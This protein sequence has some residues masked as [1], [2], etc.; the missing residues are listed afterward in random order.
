[1]SSSSLPSARLQVRQRLDCSNS[2]SNVRRC[3]VIVIVLHR[4]NTEHTLS[5]HRKREN[6]IESEISILSFHKFY[7]LFNIEPVGSVKP[8]VNIGDKTNI[9]NI[10]IHHQINLLCP[11]Q[12]FPVPAYRYAK[13]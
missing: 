4:A 7:I 9:A 10:R 13:Q 3:N 12:A 2:I 1:M 6:F 5:Q 11:A 8:N